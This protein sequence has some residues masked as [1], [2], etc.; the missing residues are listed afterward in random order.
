MTS[1]LTHPLPWR[2]QFVWSLLL[3]LLLLLLFSL[4]DIDRTVSDALFQADDR[5]PFQN[6]ESFEYWCHWLPRKLAALAF[7]TIVVIAV[8]PRRGVSWRHWHVPMWLGIVAMLIATSLVGGLKATTGNFCPIHFERYG[9]M[10]T[11]TYFGPWPYY[12]S[13]AGKCWPAGHAS[14][15]LAFTALFF[16][17]HMAGYPR[18]A[19]GALWSALVFGNVLGLS[20]VIRGQHFLSHQIWSMAICWFVPLSLFWLASRWQARYQS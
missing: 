16:S 3:T 5:F 7:F 18:L 11:E 8:V 12:I 14:N 19:K 20:Q 1:S 15:G 2:A 9:G 13:A 17:F 4:F 6:S 10:V